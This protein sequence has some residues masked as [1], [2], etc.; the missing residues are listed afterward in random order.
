[1]K[2]S[3]YEYELKDFLDELKSSMTKDKKDKQKNRGV[4][5]ELRKLS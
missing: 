4:F 1:M 3:L 5:T 2:N